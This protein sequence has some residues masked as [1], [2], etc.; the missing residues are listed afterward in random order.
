MKI[1]N[2]L[3][4]IILGSLLLA[5]CSSNTTEDRPI[6]YCETFYQY[7]WCRVLLGRNLSKVDLRIIQKPNQSIHSIE[8]SIQSI[9]EIEKA[10]M[11]IYTGGSISDWVTPSEYDLNLTTALETDVDGYSSDYDEHFWTSLNLSRECI[12]EIANGLIQILPSESSAITGNC[13]AYLYEMYDLFTTYR[14]II[15]SKQDKYI[16]I[17]D[18]SPIRYL[19][20]DFGITV[21]SPGICGKGAVENF[22]STLE[23]H[24]TN[25]IYYTES[26]EIAEE[27]KNTYSAPDTYV[28]YL[29]AC[30]SYSN[31]RES[32]YLDDYTIMLESI[33]GGMV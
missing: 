22:S 24:D 3:A 21:E 31:L 5:G 18:K 15:A 10:N 23:D 14:D 29:N 32:S 33:V 8:P 16:Y 25:S 17:A 27:V 9:P 6:V 11:I 1:V 7:D 28:V 13:H 26:E 4:Y 20:D 19:C 12:N 30:E 2:R